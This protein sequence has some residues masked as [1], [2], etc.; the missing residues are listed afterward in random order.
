MDEEEA[1]ETTEDVLIADEVEDNNETGVSTESH[2][3]PK[4]SQN[5]TYVYKKHNK[6]KH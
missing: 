6:K 5:N 3:Q 4:P 1:E 2:K